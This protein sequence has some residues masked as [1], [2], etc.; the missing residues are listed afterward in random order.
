[1]ELNSQNYCLHLLGFEHVEIP[2]VSYDCRDIKIHSAEEVVSSPEL[3]ASWAF[4]TAN[5]HGWSSADPSSRAHIRACHETTCCA[6][7][8][9]S[10]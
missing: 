1:M 2:R 8:T 5:S 4:P 7:I 3:E 10:Y 6:H 9:R